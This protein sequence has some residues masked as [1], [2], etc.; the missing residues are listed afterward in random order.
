MFKNIYYNHRSNKI[1]LWETI[2]GHSVKV[3]DDFENVYYMQDTTG[4][5]DI[6]DI[7][8]RPMVKKIQ[9]SRD[10]I[11]NLKQ[12][13]I[14]LAESD[15]QPEVKYLQSR[16]K[17]LELKTNINDFNVCYIDIEIAGS[18]EFPKPEEAKYPIN[19]I[20]VKSS[21]TGEITT[22]GSEAY[23]GDSALI[24]TYYH[25]PDETEMLA[26]FVRWFRKEKFDIITGWNVKRFDI[27]YIVNRLINLN[28]PESKIENLLSPI[29]KLKQK[30]SGEW[31]IAG[32][33]ILD[34]LEL[35]KNFTF[36]TEE[37]YTLQAIGMKVVNEGKIDLDGSINT[38][39][40]TDWNK[41]VDYNVQDVLLVEKIDSK[42]KF[43][44]LAITFCYQALIPLENVFSSIATIEG[45][46]LK[47]LHQKNLVMPDRQK[48]VQD[49][50]VQEG[51]YKKRLP[52]GS[53][54]YQNINSDNEIYESY[55]KGG[56]VEANPGFYKHVMSF[57]VTSLYPH[58][59][60]QYNISPETKVIKPTNFDD[61]IES[62][63][64]QVYYKKDK[65][66]ILPEIV[67]SI[68]NERKMF[69]EKMFTFKK[70][71]DEYKY[72]DSQQHVR[73][74]LINSMY[75]V[76]I[77]EYFHFYDL[78]N[79]RAITRG[80]RVLIK[81]LSSNTNDWFHNYFHK[82]GPKLFPGSSS[83]KITK[84][85]V[86]VC[87]TDSNYVC[88]DEI[89]EKYAKDMDFMQF[90]KIMEP[91]LHDFYEKILKIK[92]DSKGMKQVI[93]FKR[94]GIITKQFVLAKKKYLVELL[95]KEEDIYDPPKIVAT[96]VEIKRSD[97]P[98]FCRKNIEIAVQDIFDN[99]D[100]EKNIS[101]IKRTFKK[102][103]LQKI[104]D[105]ASI[106]SVKEYSKY[107]EPTSYYIKNGLK[108][109]PG[110]PM[111]NKSAICYNYLV[112]TQKLPLMEVSNGTKIKYI[113]VD[114][115]NVVNND[116]I[117]WV[118][119]YPESFSNQ[120]KINYE[121]QF[122]KTFLGV[123]N[124]MHLVLGWADSNGIQLKGNKLK[125]F[126]N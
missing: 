78:D 89:K 83:V 112:K 17:S 65:K 5:S 120:F 116:A 76:L 29:N 33:S 113:R 41:F 84:P 47:Y 67:E 27:M 118:G 110:T 42:K 20:T 7:Y 105:I 122:E 6:K 34:Y 103:K 45:Y 100:K 43:I 80:G 91:L 104:D 19:L 11:K 39:Y 10:E 121:E 32:I 26:K 50:W 54:E 97:T 24:N 9:S 16:Y 119:N 63:I 81:Y 126:M 94:E 69:K 125:G 44:E 75:G 90:A 30:R 114:P 102:F 51:H 61:L 64:N 13:N 85:L 3:E 12:L 115:I 4:M 48:N 53:Y 86:S 109:K 37:S 123:L 36:V 107:A 77:N 35:Y 57:D 82:I 31:E 66:G 124:R 99:L 88:L 98:A 96:G 73:K 60:I 70:G 71:S 87:D 56:Y 68:F 111:R 55:V 1:Y 108:F 72:Y 21:K 38:I 18:N 40:K 117:A 101:L 2:N 106:G 52:D 25:I 74:I 46:I 23:T 28:G 15:I 59:I 49:W 93:D 14:K 79:A 62:E 95:Q 22:F 58:M 8:G 92:A